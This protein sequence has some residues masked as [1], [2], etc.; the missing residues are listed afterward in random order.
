MTARTALL[1]SILACF[2]APLHADVIVVDKTGLA[3]SWSSARPSRSCRT[4]A[5]R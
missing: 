2:V 5:A 1:V 3:S 4:G